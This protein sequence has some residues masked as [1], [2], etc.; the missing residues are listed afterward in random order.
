MFFMFWMY[1]SAAVLLTVAECSRS[2][3]R[4]TVLAFKHALP[5]VAPLN[6]LNLAA[7]LTYMTALHLAAASRF[8]IL[9]RSNM[10]FGFVLS[11]VL[12]H[13]LEGWAWKL[14]G[15]MLIVVGAALITVT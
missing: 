3:C 8:A 7:M 14:V 10:V 4:S 13:E 2:G 9:M 5:E 6:L 1:T 12:L 15:A 11:L